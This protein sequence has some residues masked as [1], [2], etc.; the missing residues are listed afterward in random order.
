VLNL[1][2]LFEV[3]ALENLTLFANPSNHYENWFVLGDYLDV[4]TYCF[5][6]ILLSKI[7]HF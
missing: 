5:G 2:Q 3:L 7:N 4:N 6:F 1:K